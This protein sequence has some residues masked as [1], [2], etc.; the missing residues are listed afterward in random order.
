M[1]QRNIKVLVL[2]ALRKYTLIHVLG[3]MHGNHLQALPS[4]CTYFLYLQ[5]EHNVCCLT[6]I[7][8]FLTQCLNKNLNLAIKERR[9]C[10]RRTTL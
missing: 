8:I 5:K 10:K 7:Q 9:L 2:T 4:Y 3:S 6:E 1:L